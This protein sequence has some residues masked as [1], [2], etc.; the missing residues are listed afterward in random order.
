M[1]F[2]RL[3]DHDA[4]GFSSQAHFELFQKENVIFNAVS[5]ESYCPSHVGCLSLKTTFYGEE[6]YFVDNRRLP[7]RPGHCLI[8]NDDQPY[9]SRIERGE[10]TR[11]LSIFFQKEFAA[12]VFRDALN[13]EDLLLDDPFPADSPLPTF[14]A[15][16]HP[17]GLALARQLTALRV[18][19]DTLGYEAGR[20]GE[21]LIDL[22]S[23][24]MEAFR[25]ER[26]MRERVDALRPGTRK[27]IFRRLCIAREV[28]HTSFEQP[29]D[30]PALS[31][32]AC[33]SVPQ[34]V[35]QFKAVFGH[36]PHRYLVKVRLEHAAR[37]L[38]DTALPVQDIAWRSGFKDVS[39]FCR[40]FKG[41]YKASPDGYRA[42]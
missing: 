8:L 39:A 25:G 17:M 34:L 23:Y 6:S 12:S 35:R 1:Y 42:G 31:S 36:T 15:N 7:L 27:E 24:M 37:W 5:S 41:V 10:S 28:L 33:L 38:S 11:L 30:L 26:Q 16:L 19:L 21:R 9:G 3:P 18:E 40:A 2:T 32:M 29:I 14:A 13:P 20:T 22:L 4:P